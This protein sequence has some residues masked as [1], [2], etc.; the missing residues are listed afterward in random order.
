MK[1]AF[2]IIS[3]IIMVVIL[4]TSCN[5]DPVSQDPEDGHHKGNLTT[6]NNED[7]GRNT[8]R[9]FKIYK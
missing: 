1:K 5:P 4:I 6:S 3:L 2:T 8:H 7:T 9:S